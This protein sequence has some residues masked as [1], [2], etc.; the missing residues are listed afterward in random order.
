MLFLLFS[1]FHVTLGTSMTD[2]TAILFCVPHALKLTS[3]NVLSEIQTCLEDNFIRLGNQTVLTTYVEAYDAA[4]AAK[5]AS[6]R[7]DDELFLSKHEMTISM[8]DLRLQAA[9]HIHAIESCASISHRMPS[10]VVDTFTDEAEMMFQVSDV[11]MHH[12]QVDLKRCYKLMKKIVTMS[13]RHSAHHLQTLFI[14]HK[15]LLHNSDE[16]HTREVQRLQDMLDARK[17]VLAAVNI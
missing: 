15:H 13:H 14:K 11:W 7:A 16:K 5:L 9:R 10:T 3:G 2:T 1:F 8:R 6:E 17:N 12:I 4:V